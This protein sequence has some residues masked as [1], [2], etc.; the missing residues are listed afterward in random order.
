MIKYAKGYA[1]NLGGTMKPPIGF[2]ESTA[3]EFASAVARK[4]GVIN[5][6]GLVGSAGLP[7]GKRILDTGH[8]SANVPVNDAGDFSY[9]IKNRVFG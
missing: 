6:A 7:H 3:K 2:C 8:F 9:D 5:D 1:M 4:A